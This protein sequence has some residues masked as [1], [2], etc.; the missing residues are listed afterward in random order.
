M[1]LKTVSLFLVA[2]TATGLLLGC[3]G[4]QTTSVPVSVDG[5]SE[6][7]E[8][9]QDISAELERLIDEIR[10][11]HDDIQTAIDDAEN[12]D[13][14]EDNPWHKVDAFRQALSDIQDKLTDIDSA[15]SELEM[16]GDEID[17]VCD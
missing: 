15:I 12:A 14:V 2:S 3:R 8:K 4:T 13:L 11:A 1:R 17:S 10:S 16:Q 7:R 9:A 6:C 5:L